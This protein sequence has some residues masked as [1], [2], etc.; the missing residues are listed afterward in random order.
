MTASGA[1]DANADVIDGH[2]EVDNVNVSGQT[3]GGLLDI[4]AG[5]QANTLIISQIIVCNCWHWR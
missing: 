3:A 1:I 2:L 4:N 5:A